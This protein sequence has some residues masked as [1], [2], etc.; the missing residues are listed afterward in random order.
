LL[1]SF[2]LDQPLETRMKDVQFAFF[3]PGNNPAVWRDGWYPDVAKAQMAATRA[4]PAEGWWNAGSATPLLVIQ[5]LQD[6][7]APP[8]NGH[9]MK[10]EMA[11]RVELIDIDGAGHAMLPEQPEKIAQ[12]IIDFSRARTR[13][14]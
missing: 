9:M 8:E 1:G 5:G 6:V 2:R 3:A 11:G 13:A 14:K 12:A 10:D 7:V 4:T